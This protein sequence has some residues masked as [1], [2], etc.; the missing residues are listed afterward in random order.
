MQFLILVCAGSDFAPDIET[1]KRHT[2]AWVDEVEGKGMRK[3]G[4]RAY[5]PE[6]ADREGGRRE[7]GRHARSTGRRR[8]ADRR[9]RPL[10]PSAGTWRSRRV[11][12]TTTSTSSSLT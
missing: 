8:R 1:M 9:L 3:T 11:R 4:A 12:C 6:D 7:G 2:V 10:D 5:A